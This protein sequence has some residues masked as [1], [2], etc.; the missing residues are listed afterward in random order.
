VRPL[1]LTSQRKSEFF[2]SLLGKTTEI[3]IP[4][5][6]GRVPRYFGNR[7]FADLFIRRNVNREVRQ[8][9]TGAFLG[10]R[11]DVAID[12]LRDAAGVWPTTIFGEAYMGFQ[13]FLLDLRRQQEPAK[14]DPCPGGCYIGYGPQ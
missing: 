14:G 1:P 12:I 9:L 13:L 2:S 11:G 3:L 7:S 6:G 4:R 8:A 5:L 10:S